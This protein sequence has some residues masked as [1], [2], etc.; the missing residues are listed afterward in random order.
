MKS[1]F[2]TS[3]VTILLLTGCVIGTTTKDLLN[4][5]SA[6]TVTFL[7][8][9]SG[10]PLRGV[11]VHVE[12][13]FESDSLLKMGTYVTIAEG[14]TNENGTFTYSAELDGSYLILLMKTPLRSFRDGIV[15][16]ELPNSNQSQVVQV[17][18]YDS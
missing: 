15:T 8:A 2:L 9:T 16:I 7:D 5:E 13:F 12:R 17:S 11:R 3:L 1:A 6:I 4:Q 14:K 18:D 10:S